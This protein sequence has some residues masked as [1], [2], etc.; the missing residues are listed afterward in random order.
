VNSAALRPYKGYGVIRLSQNAGYSKYNALQISADRRYRNGFKFGLA[1]TL[2]HS[3]DNASSKRDVL[4]NAFDDSGFWG[5]SS[6]DR[7]HVFNFYYIYDLPFFSEQNSIVSRV[8]G[9]WQIAGSTFM[10]TGTPLWVT[11]TSDIAGVGDAFAQPYN[12]VG[13]PSGGSANQQFSGGVAADQNFW[14]NPQAFSAPSAGTFGNAP[15]NDIYNP[16]QYQWDIAFFK[17]VAV[18]G[19]QNIQFRAEIFNFPN[20]ANLSGAQAD[21]TNA[22]FGR[23][24][25]KDDSRRDI[26]LSLR[27]L[28]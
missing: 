14:F 22:T 19:T 20:H 12:Q 5:N 13:D 23:V 15:R 21:P 6:F 2:S 4:F 9:G 8:L 1:Y 16:G 10:R 7:R 3:E 27:Y 18:K 24:T 25:G 26:Q 11:K 28:F 17:N